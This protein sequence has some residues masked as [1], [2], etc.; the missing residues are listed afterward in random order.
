MG[1]E[2]LV[3]QAWPALEQV[4]IAGWRARFAEGVTARANS[5]S[6]PDGPGD[7]AAVEREY[8]RRGLPPTFQVSPESRPPGLDEELARRGYAAVK[9]TVIMTAELAPGPV[10]LPVAAEPSPE[11]LALWW[12]VDG[13]Y[14]DQL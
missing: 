8:A 6:C 1:F 11:W 3:G 10:E 9:H 4:E 2:S 12:S 7:I 13:R 14:A 5:V